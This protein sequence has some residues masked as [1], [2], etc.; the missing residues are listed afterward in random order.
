MGS[1]KEC[2]EMGNQE[3][4]TN[5]CGA[6]VLEKNLLNQQYTE[7]HEERKY[8]I[9]YTKSDEKGKYE[10]EFQK[11]L[12]DDIEEMFKDMP[13]TKDTTCGFWIFRGSFFQRFANKKSYVFIYGVVGC[14]FSATYAYFNGTIT[15]LEKR[16]K[17]PSK[18]TG[19]ISVGNDISSLFL[20]AILSYYA[21]KG[22]RPR[23]ISFGLFT[24]VTFCWLT[25]L[26]HLLYGPGEAALFLTTEF[27]A[28]Y[29]ENQT[30]EVFEAQKAK[31]LCRANGTRGAE[32]ETEEGNLAPQAI[33]FVAQFIS[34]IGSSL[35]Y[36]LGVSYMDDN[37]KKSKTPALVSV[38][39]FLRMLG[40]A[41]GYALASYCLKLYI[42]PSMTPTITN[43][44]PRWL[45]AWWIGWLILGAVLAFA[46]IF[47]AMFPK[48]LPRAAIRKRIA[49][50]KQK[51]GM[52]LS[53][54]KKEDELPASFKDMIKTFKRLVKNKILMLNNIASVFYFF[55]FMPYWIFTPKYIET[56]YKQ[57][58]STSSLVTGTVALV[59]SAIG[60][61]LSG[62]IISRY[63]PRARYM[64]A[65]NVLVGA[66]SVIGMV[67]YAFLGCAASENSVIV[68]HPST[69][70]L[71]PTC[72]SACQC[73]YVKYS[74]I[75]GED[76]NTYISACHAGCKQQYQHGD[77]KLYDECS[78]ISPQNFTNSQNFERMRDLNE[79]MASHFDMSFDDSPHPGGRALG[80]PCPLDCKREFI[81][82]LVV[83]CFLKFSGATGRASNFLVSVRCVDEK[84]KT[85][86][87]GFGMM[88]LSLMS[89]IPS[90]IFFGLVL[91]K[92]C[93][94]WGKTCSG[95]GN[96]WLYDGESL[97]YL[98]NFT[99]AAFVL[100]GTLVDCGVWY[101]VKDLKIFDDEVKDKEITIA[102]KEE[103]VTKDRPT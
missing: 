27:G 38:S 56:Q 82:F 41:M 4:T 29:D 99:A 21:G 73:D 69:T 90:P 31:T 20:S 43:K 49:A 44:D 97:R 76:G 100:V 72:N 25:A 67:V 85:V 87:M 68:N 28:T 102:D 61:L 23:W 55:G 46:A 30:K 39:Y 95:K 6:N 24:I 78:C 53:E 34:G 89:F 18:N 10:P 70:D 81:T 17:I 66:L 62:I 80:G 12:P 98:L 57:S 71:T 9:V 84:D 63:K 40:P 35:Y 16:Y 15:T 7:C 79:T 11:M 3:K 33:L 103:E 65:W 14:I 48:Q 19:I 101:Y 88:M 64:A 58:A 47:M 59:F 75:C 42:S 37:I 22:N 2:P 1:E 91:D 83:M 86:S 50:E 94:V 52:K 26:P 96:C 45:G 54:A 93:L 51:L 32:C 8:D 60:V 13:L 5:G 77:L 36:T 74:P 92:T